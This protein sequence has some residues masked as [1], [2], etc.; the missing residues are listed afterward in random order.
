MIKEKNKTK[1]QNKQWLQIFK[2]KTF[3]KWCKYNTIILIL[4]TS[5]ILNIIYI[6]KVFN[7]T[8]NENNNVINI[9]IQAINGEKSVLAKSNY[10]TTFNTLG[11]LLNACSND[12]TIEKSQFGRFLVAVKGEQAPNKFWQIEYWDGKNFTPTAVGMDDIKLK[13]N[14][15]FQFDLIEFSTIL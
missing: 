2:N 6:P 11:N 3:I 9:E 8:T 1:K 7:G 12:F 5:L 4:G 10:I 14:D 13:N 15:W